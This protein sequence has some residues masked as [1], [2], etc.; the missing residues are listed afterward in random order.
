MTRP[1]KSGGAT[2]AALAKY[3]DLSPRRVQQL[4]NEG[5][6]PRLRDN[7]F[8]LDACR[9][10]YIRYLRDEGR[11]VSPSDARERTQVARA[12]EI[13]LRLARERGKLIELETVELVE[14]E[15]LGKLYSQLVGLP[16]ACTRDLPLRKIIE[17][18]LNDALG[19]CRRHFEERSAA[20]RAG[21][22]MFPDDEEADA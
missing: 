3:L 9:L 13:E 6:L 16:A 2:T 15:I 12:D 5:V 11:R 14:A 1:M 20:L 7:T 21:R 10:R 18:K 8:D 22:E 19:Q 17:E 4:A